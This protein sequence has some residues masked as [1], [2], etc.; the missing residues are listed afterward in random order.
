MHLFSFNKDHQ[1]FTIYLIN[2]PD[3]SLTD[4]VSLLSNKFCRPAFTIFAKSMYL[5]GLM[6]KAKIHSNQKVT[7]P[8]PYNSAYYSR[9][10][11]TH[12]PYST[13]LLKITFRLFRALMRSRINPFCI[14]RWSLWE[15][16]ST[17]FIL[18]P[19]YLS[20][21]FSLHEYAATVFTFSLLLTAMNLSLSPL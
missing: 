12:T 2:L 6:I 3:N 1:N 20:F 11:Y 21:L 8:F 5:N 7:G 17:V 9:L 14:Q 15:K 13:R 16:V 18:F 4:N 10:G 19:T